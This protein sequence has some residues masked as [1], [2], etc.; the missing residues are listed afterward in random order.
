M[1]KPACGECGSCSIAARNA[2]IAHNSL[3]I[4]LHMQHRYEDAIPVLE[5][6][7]ASDVVICG[8]RVCANIDPKGQ[9]TGDK[10]QYV[11]VQPRPRQ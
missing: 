9:R 4:L 8:D 1:L 7:Y 6:Y 11:Q 3:G 2:A 10:R 5:A